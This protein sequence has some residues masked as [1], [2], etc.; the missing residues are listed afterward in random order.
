MNT[1]TLFETLIDPQQLIQTTAELIR[2]PSYP[3]VA[4]QETA[5][6]RYIQDR[7]AKAGIECH[8]EEVVDGRPN[9]I[10]VLPGSGDGRSLLL[11]GHT[12]TVPPYDMPDAL[13][14]RLEGE[15]ITGR[16][17]ADMKGP[18]A[19]MIETMLAVKRSGLKLRGDLIFAGVIDEE[20]R[21]YGAVDLI[22]KGIL[23]HGA[24][25]G[26][27]TNS[28]LCVAH[29]GLE[30]FDFCFKGK[31]VHGGDQ[32][33][34]V[35]AISK[36]AHFICAVEE[37]LLPRL[38][39][40]RDPL[41]GSPTANIGVIRGG[42]QLSTV[43]GACTVSIDRRFIPGETYEEVCAEFTRLLN[44]LAAKDPDFACEMKVQD[45]SV[46]K[47]GYVHMPLART[48]DESFIE[49]LRANINA[50]YGQDTEL[51]SFQAWS[52]AGILSSYGKIPSVVFGPGLIKCCHSA[53]EY[54]T[55]PD[56]TKACLAY[57]LIAIEFCA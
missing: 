42:T 27:P 5:V 52:D 20:M 6:A 38:E 28:K 13:A 14:P 25:V 18:I 1:Q 30:W 12:D 54:I 47:N 56:L 10:A 34:G 37:A 50:A 16:G 40:R 32:A 9:V 41:M 21:S 55:V 33:H 23:A 43:A 8:L 29:R 53:S 39:E 46:M 22:E 44:D 3:G 19:S 35:N 31:T 51:T 49:L 36:A 11:C 48:T 7:M 26:E 15:R 2:I 4:E 24:I 57:A 17:A 45:V